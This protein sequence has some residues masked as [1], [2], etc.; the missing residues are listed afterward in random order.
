MANLKLLLIFSTLLSI[1]IASA[2]SEYVSKAF[3]VCNPDRF[4]SLGL[5]ISAFPYCNESLPYYE[6]AKDLVG[7]MSLK[8][9]VAQLGNKAKGALRIGLPP[10]E[11]WSEALHGVSKTGPGT[12]FNATI[13]GATSFPTVILSAASFNESLWNAIGQVY[14]LSFSHSLIIL[15][16]Y[17]YI[18]TWRQR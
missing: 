8:E 12:F 9:K 10:Y 1:S 2:T 11:W 5:D 6:R 7:S 3:H 17:L 15:Y 13:P 4:T 18:H 16:V 14:L